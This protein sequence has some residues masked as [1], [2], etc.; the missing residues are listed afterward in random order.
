MEKE[1]RVMKKTLLERT[2]EGRQN[3]RKVRKEEEEDGG[4]M[5]AKSKDGGL[6]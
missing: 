5:R 3:N 2:K 4:K 6:W 1:E